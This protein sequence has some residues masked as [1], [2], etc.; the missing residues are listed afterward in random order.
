MNPSHWAQFMSLEG[1]N[2][3]KS[4]LVVKVYNKKN[5]RLEKGKRYWPY[6][7]RKEIQ[8]Y[9]KDT[10]LSISSLLEDENSIKQTVWGD[11]FTSTYAFHQLYYR[12]F[13]N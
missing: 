3:K 10:S 4:E 13:S 2:Y 8:H 9:L 11:Q 7:S 5:Q 12:I 1:G 6:E